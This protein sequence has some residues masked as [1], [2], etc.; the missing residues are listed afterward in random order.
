MQGDE[1]FFN[2]LREVFGWNDMAPGTLLS[3]LASRSGLNLPELIP[4]LKER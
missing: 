1:A 4:R 3:L 2:R